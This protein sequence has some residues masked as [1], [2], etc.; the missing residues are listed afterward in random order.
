MKAFVKHTV[1]AAVCLCAAL[2]LA[3]QQQNPVETRLEA[4]KVVPAADGKET[5]ASADAAR[6]GDVIEYA[7]TYRNTS[8]QP[9]KNL[10]ATLPIPDKTEYL[11]G[12]A[13]PANAQAGLDS[14]AFAAIPLKRTVTRNGARVEEQ[15]PF[16]EYRYLR[17][18]PGELGAD[19]VVTF[20]A[21][22]RVVDD[23]APGEPGKGG[24]R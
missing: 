6:P 18:F 24:G 17:W 22:V 12:S 9:V 16:R 19:Q 5:F 20:T 8:R 4:R 7:A 23:R 3:A 2:P 10:V 1:L 15:V 11:P 21:R 13:R 14:S